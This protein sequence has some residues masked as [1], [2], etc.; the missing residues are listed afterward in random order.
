MSLHERWPGEHGQS[1]VG[2]TEAARRWS[3]GNAG[4][5]VAMNAGPLYCFVTRATADDGGLV[6]ACTSRALHDD[7]QPV[8]SMESGWEQ[9]RPRIVGATRSIDECG[10][11]L[12][13]AHVLYLCREG[14][15]Q[16]DLDRGDPERVATLVLRVLVEMVGERP[17]FGSLQQAC[18]AISARYDAHILSRH[19]QI[20]GAA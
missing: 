9:L 16:V 20:A 14:W 17:S 4:L 11:G 2:L 7:G 15:A 1:P 13:Q 19:R 5:A 18:V 12:Y 8:L 10:A 3:A 6:L